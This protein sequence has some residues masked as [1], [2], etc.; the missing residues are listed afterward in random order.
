MGSSVL[1]LVSSCYT[2]AA[3]LRVERKMSVLS[4]YVK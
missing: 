2:Q 1:R 4:S 3:F